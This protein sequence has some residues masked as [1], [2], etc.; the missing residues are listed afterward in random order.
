MPRRLS[1]VTLYARLLVGAVVG[2]A[3]GAI[4]TPFLGIAA[5]LLA[6]WAALCVVG[7]AWLLLTVW[8]MDAVQ[9]RRH[10]TTED[11][12]R[13]LARAIA[14][15]GSVAS[16]G[17]V[18][19]VLLETRNTSQF[20]SFLLAGI[21]VLSVASSW[22]LI[23]V[24]YMLR[25]ANVYYREPVGGISFNQAEDPMYTDFIYVAVG[26]GMTYQIADTNLSTSEMRRIVIG[27]TLLAYLFGAVILATVI[28]LVTGLG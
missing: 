2:V 22:A 10:A 8:P 16:L 18:A 4:T 12:G 6:G 19:V 11:P 15:L 21:S 20:E 27:Q 25:L 1:R 5:G 14:V 13:P 3:V 9:T 26:L 24:D 17:A 28:N 7:V 23:Q